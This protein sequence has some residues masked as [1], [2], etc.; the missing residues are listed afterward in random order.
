VDAR[1][2]S[3]IG[4]IDRLC[5]LPI[6]SYQRYCHALQV[7]FARY[8]TDRDVGSVAEEVR[9]LD[10]TNVFFKIEKMEHLMTNHDQD[11]AL[12]FDYLKKLLSENK[13]KNSQGT[14]KRI[15]FKKDEE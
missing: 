13:Q 12:L 9:S 3:R 2:G 11:I 5:R 15:G 8:D 10:C 14:R 6:F 1:L 7:V 4:F